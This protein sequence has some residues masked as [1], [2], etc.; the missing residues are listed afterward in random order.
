V[1]AKRERSFQSFQPFKPIKSLTAQMKI[2]RTNRN[3]TIGAK[4]IDFVRRD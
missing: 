3:K 2:G 1:E 4:D